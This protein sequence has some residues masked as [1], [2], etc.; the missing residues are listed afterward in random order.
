LSSASLT[1]SLL[2]AL[3]ATFHSDKTRSRCTSKLPK[4]LCNSVVLL[5]AWLISA[6]NCSFS[7]LSAATSALSCS[8]VVLAFCNSSN[9]DVL[10]FFSPVVGSPS[11]TGLSIFPALRSLQLAK[12]PAFDTDHQTVV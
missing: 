7:C 3:F 12:L 9:I 2:S 11:T 5:D 8:I 1:R 6:C 4:L 10:S